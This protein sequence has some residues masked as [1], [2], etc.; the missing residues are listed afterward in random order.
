MLSSVVPFGGNSENTRRQITRLSTFETVFICCQTGL[1]REA[2]NVRFMNEHWMRLNAFCS[3]L[4]RVDFVAEAS[5]LNNR[6]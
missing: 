5:L 4:F 1:V 2:H 6:F 3:S